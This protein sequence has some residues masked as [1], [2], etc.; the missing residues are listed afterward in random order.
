MTESRLDRIE[1]LLEQTSRDSA[2]HDRQLTEKLDQV[3]KQQAQFQD[4]L[5]ETKALQLQNAQA[6]S[7]LTQE[8]KLLR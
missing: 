7:Q 2:E 8:L 4:E 6:I 5:N 1:L 3:A